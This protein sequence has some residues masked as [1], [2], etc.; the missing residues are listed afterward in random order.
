MNY[1]SKLSALLA[2]AWLVGGAVC[3]QESSIDDMLDQLGLG[4]GHKQQAAPSRPAS[5]QP[6][7]PQTEAPQPDTSIY[8]S[9]TPL[10]TAVLAGK[11]S[12]VKA[13]LSD[14]RNLEARDSSDMTPLMLA[15]YKDR[16]TSAKLL[17]QAGAN[18]EAANI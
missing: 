15:A 7:A 18:T 16:A 10:H 2:I 5:P 11:P 1:H 8:Q 4:D 17:I 12:A 14:H 3:A 13:A 9:N 6:A